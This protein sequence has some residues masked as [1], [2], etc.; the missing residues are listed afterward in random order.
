MWFITLHLPKAY[1][2]RHFH[3]AIYQKN[4]HSRSAS[5]KKRNMEN[6]L[7]ET[8][9]KSQA[10]PKSDILT[11]PCSSS[12]MLAGFKSRYTMY[13]LKKFL[14]TII[15]QKLHAPVHVFQSQNY[16]CSIEFHLI[17]IENSMLKLW[18]MW[19]DITCL[20]KIIQNFP[21]S[22]LAWFIYY[23]KF[24]KLLYLSISSVSLVI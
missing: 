22:F 16:F 3:S 17:F 1:H 14:M 21:V 4:T 12:N 13:R 23:L 24:N 8:N 6:I 7:T 19:I 9:L 2:T 18:N 10:R 15:F 20:I 5:P 11:W